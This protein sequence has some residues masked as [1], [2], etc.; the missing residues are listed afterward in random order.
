M[1]FTPEHFFEFYGKNCCVVSSDTLLKRT[2]NLNDAQGY[3]WMVYSGTDRIAG[4]GYQFPALYS[5]IDKLGRRFLFSS[6]PW[7]IDAN[8]VH[9]GYGY[10]SLVFCCRLAPDKAQ[11]G[12]SFD[13][14]LCYPNLKEMKIRGK[15]R[16][17]HVD[18][19]GSDFVFWFQCYSDKIKKHV[20][21]ALV[22]Q[23]LNAE[24]LDGH[25]N[26]F[27]LDIDIRNPGDWVCLGSCIEKSD[28]Y[29]SLDIN[30]LDTIKPASM[31]FILTPIDA[32]PVWADECD[33]TAPLNLSYESVW[34]INPQ[35]LPIG[36]I[37]MYDLVIEY[38][39]RYKIVEVTE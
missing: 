16:G 18:L 4:D 11:Q 10:L 30:E 7:W 29:G 24:V 12:T 37:A 2:Y 38:Y 36:T 35:A 21:Y 13:P 9:P 28:R 3:P 15:I 8:H 33:L 22:G 5:K 34:P 19:K 32:K 20:N 6:G 23:P 25:I 17:C 39:S 26:D 31:G 1:N 27:E 14:N